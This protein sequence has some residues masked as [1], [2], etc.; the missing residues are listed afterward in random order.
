[1]KVARTGIQTKRLFISIDYSNINPRDLSERLKQNWKEKNVQRSRKWWRHRK[2]QNVRGDIDI[3]HII[4]QTHVI[5]SYWIWQLINYPIC[6]EELFIKKFTKQ[7]T[8]LRLENNSN[9]LLNALCFCLFSKVTAY[10]CHHVLW[11]WNYTMREMIRWRKMFLKDMTTKTTLQ[12]DIMNKKEFYSCFS[13]S[14][15]C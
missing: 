9:P 3:I 5:D 10:F 7:K 12:F 2:R 14:K 15:I 8:I 11:T 6:R 13:Q 1:M 4:Q